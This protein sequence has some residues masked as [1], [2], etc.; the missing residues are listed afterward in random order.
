MITQFNNVFEME[1]IHKI[2]HYLKQ[3]KWRFGNTSLPKSNKQFWIMELNEFDF[4]TKIL[5][6]KI[7]K[8]IGEDYYLETVYANGHTY[9]MEGEF[10]V[11]S[12]NPNGYTFLYYPHLK[13]KKSWNGC[14]TILEDN[15]TV[16]VIYPSP[17]TAVIF[18]SLLW[19]RGES[20]SR[21]FFDLR[22][23]IAFKLIKNNHG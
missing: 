8:I 18:P 1:D 15:E 13:W 9:G 16:K 5:Y 7:K 6:S 19:H 4:F 2:W 17:N 23:T 12:P 21:D 14:T 20:P 10:H 22:V 11:D 3:S